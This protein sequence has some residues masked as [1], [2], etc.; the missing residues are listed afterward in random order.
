M[1]VRW[2]TFI[3][4]VI[5]MYDAVGKP[6]SHTFDPKSL[7]NKLDRDMYYCV[8]VEGEEKMKLIKLRPGE[9]MKVVEPKAKDVEGYVDNTGHM[10][11]FSGALSQILQEKS[12]DGFV[13]QWVA[14]LDKKDVFTVDLRGVITDNEGFKRDHPEWSDCIDQMPQP[15]QGEKQIIQLGP[16]CGGDFDRCDHEKDGSNLAIRPIEMPGEG[17]LFRK[18]VKSFTLYLWNANFESTESWNIPSPHYQAVPSDGPNGYFDNHCLIVKSI[19]QTTPAPSGIYQDL[20]ILLNGIIR[21][22]CQIRKI[23][24]PD[25]ATVTIAIWSLSAGKASSTKYRIP[26]SEMYFDCYTDAF[27]EWDDIL[28]VE[29]YLPENT[30]YYIGGAYLIQQYTDIK[31]EYRPAHP[32][33]RPHDPP[34][35]GP[36]DRGGPHR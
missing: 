9:N 31:P 35:R 19:P 24:G 26:V 34:D 25:D 18:G 29:I 1:T 12:I 36:Y 3:E 28:R 15:Q 6:E 8:S 2:S 17:G 33:P 30:E 4:A 23:S 22:G 5:E 16:K 14:K 13:I 20:D 21:F 7:T 27:V 32:A 10:V 11:K